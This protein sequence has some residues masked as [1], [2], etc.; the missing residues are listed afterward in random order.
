MPCWRRPI[1]NRKRAGTFA[2]FVAAALAS[3]PGF[4]TA[5]ELH[6]RVGVEFEHFGQSYRVSDDEDTV[7]TINDV[8]T[9]LGATLTAGDETKARLRADAGALFGIQSI[10]ARLAVQGEVRRGANLF[11]AEQ[12]ATLRRFR[13]DGDYSLSSD[14]FQGNARFA[15][16]RSLDASTSLR[17]QD[18]FELVRYA[19]PD[20]YNLNS[21][22]HR[23]QVAFR[24]SFGVAGWT[25]AAYSLGA[26][27]VPDS[28]V[29]DSIR[30]TGEIDVGTFFGEAASVDA[31]GRVDRRIY[32]VESPRE[33]S[34]ETRSDATIESLGSGR[35]GWRVRPELETVR[36]DSPD[37]LDFDFTRARIAAGPVVRLTPEFDVSVGPSFERLNS[38]TALDEE[39]DQLGV[40]VGVE[41]RG[42]RVWVHVSDEIARRDYTR[43]ATEEEIDLD[44]PLDSSFDEEGLYSDSIVNRL[45]VLV[46]AELTAHTS[47]RLFANWEPEDHRLDRDDAETSLLSGGIE[48]RF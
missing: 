42:A 28:S 35:L 11:R 41:W 22:L 4:A 33:S 48:H 1:W 37:E 2:V 3:L 43:E 40:E 38:S 29:L 27:D 13:D 30:H 21:F 8:G 24:R 39:Y 14:S 36:F 25:R 31:A 32:D 6:P 44:A 47:L 17:L 16:E 7:T 45:T 23:P 46:S 9:S 10:R 34:W 18:S 5:A 15:W 26:R 20:E 19:D 12:D